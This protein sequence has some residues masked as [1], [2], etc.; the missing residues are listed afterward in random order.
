MKRTKYDIKR[1]TL[2]ASLAAIIAVLSLLYI[3]AYPTP[4]TL[5]LFAVYFSLYLG[6]GAIGTL[7]VFIYIAIGCLGLPVFSGFRGGVGALF[8]ATGGFIIGFLLLALVYWALTSCIKLKKAKL[9]ASLISLATLY[10]AGVVWYTVVYLDGQGF[11]GAVLVTV[12]PFVLPDLLKM[13]LA[14]LLAKRLKEGMK[15]LSY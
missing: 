5:Q 2:T 10:A 6:G 9:V 4:F 8:D 3:P 7:A 11:L 1:L 14:Y 15:F 13:Y 12:L